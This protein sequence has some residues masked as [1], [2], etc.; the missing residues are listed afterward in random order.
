[1]KK[2]SFFFTFCFLLFTFLANAQTQFFSTVK[3][4]FEKTV[5]MR[6]LYKELFPEDYDDWKDHV[7]P[8]HNKLF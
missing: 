5:A 4:E 2:H 6:A 8:K 1:M 7:P 3:I